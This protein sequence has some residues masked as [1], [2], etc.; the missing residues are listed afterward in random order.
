MRGPVND[1]GVP[2]WKN[3]TV[4][5]GDNLP[6]M[7]GMNSESVDL[8]HLDPPL[9]FQVEPRRPNREP[10]GRCRIQGHLDAEPIWT[11]RWLDL[12]RAKHPALNRV[13]RAAMTDSGQVIPGLHGG[14]PAGDEAAAQADRIVSA[15]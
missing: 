7:R 1:M 8:I 11:T 5:T 10:G 15:D 9:Q 2:N 13:I 6:I 14:A 12:I 3:K 4:W